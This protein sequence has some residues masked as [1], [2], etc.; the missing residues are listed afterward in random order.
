MLRNVSGEGHLSGGQSPS[1]PPVHAVASP[2]LVTQESSWIGLPS[3]LS[4]AA[5]SFLHKYLPGRTLGYETRSGWF[6]RDL[7]QNLVDD[8]SAFLRQLDDVVPQRCHRCERDGAAGLLQPAAWVTADSLR[9]IGIQES[10]EVDV[11]PCQPGQSGS[12]STAR[13]FLS[14]V[15]LSAGSSQ[16]KRHPD[17]GQDWVTSRRAKGWWGSLWGSDEASLWSGPPW[18][19]EG[20]LTCQ[21]CPLNPAAGS[22]VPAVNTSDVIVYSCNRVWTLGETTGR[23]DHKDEPADREDLHTA[24][25]SSQGELRTPDQDYGYSSLEEEHF[26]ISHLNVM[27]APCEDQPQQPVEPNKSGTAANS[28]ADVETSEAGEEERDDEAEPVTVE[29]L[30]A[31]PGLSSPQCQ[32]KTIAYIMGCPC[33]DDDSQSDR[34]SSEEEEE[35]DDD[36]DD[37]FDSECLSDSADEDDDEASDSDCEADSETEHLWTFLCQS[38]DPYNPQNFTARLH[39]GSTTEPRPVPCTLTSTQSTPD[40][41][42]DLTPLPL[43]S[44][45]SLQVSSS[46][47]QSQDS[48]DDSTSASEV[49]EAESLRLWRSFSSKADPYSPFNFQ[50]SLATRATSGGEPSLSCLQHSASSP[51]QYR[52]EEAEER[53]DS[54]FSEPKASSSSSSLPSAVSSA[55]SCITVKRVR[56]CED[57]EE[58]FASG[59]EEEEDRRGPWEELARDRCRFLRR[60]Q[61]VEQSIAFCLQPGHRNLVYQR[62][63]L[64]EGTAGKLTR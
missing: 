52:K 46:S 21:F 35:D 9:Q 48:W 27:K 38:Q 55:S 22:K 47:P 30:A 28:E 63:R 37:G 34:E 53:L 12:F 58:F 32:N 1:A 8:G 62:L 14:H 61:E 2:V 7:K 10:D 6:S 24:Q 3:V 49:D 41:S 31:D 4:R 19:D 59:G 39:T 11:R 56:F 36:D 18:G 5:L 43:T 44:L 16:E 42:P 17:G 25:R 40:P 15:L 20:K 13:T 51:P 57:V 26:H 50:A 54:G 60:C 29:S 64:Q 33:S 23:G 45:S